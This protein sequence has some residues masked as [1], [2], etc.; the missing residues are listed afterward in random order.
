[1]Q[2]KP[3]PVII[4]GTAGAAILV[5]VAIAA[6]QS[7]LRPKTAEVNPISPTALTAP[8]SITSP[9][10]PSPTLN[11]E[12]NLP[13]LTATETEVKPTPKPQPIALVTP[14]VSPNSPVAIAVTNQTKL[15]HV[16]RTPQICKVTMARVLERSLDVRSSPKIETNNVI[17]QIQPQSFIAVKTEQN[18][19]L[20]LSNPIQGWI[21]KALVE[22]TCNQKVERVRFARNTDAATIRDRFIGSGHHQYL[23]RATKAQIMTIKATKG[24]VPSV[25]APD[26]KR[27]AAG[28]NY[29]LDQP[30]TLEL[31]SSGD[32][33]LELDSN[34]KGYTYEF[35]IQ[36]K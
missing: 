34:F 32:Y 22:S 15:E 1:M 27:I 24:V 3:T 12:K 26:G 21:P 2:L 11:S 20:E 31:P 10:A 13:S 25:I 6:L 33:T 23:L 19:W 17:G 8:I 5:G 35:L 7:H 16:T 29:P 4:G 9:A 30:L 28:D 36:I 14:T 18:D